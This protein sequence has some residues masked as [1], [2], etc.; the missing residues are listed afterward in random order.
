MKRIPMKT[1]TIILAAAAVLL[2]FE[3]ANAQVTYRV[4]ATR[5]GLVGHTTANGHVIQPNDRF[6]ALPSRTVLNSN[7]GTTYT[8]TISNPANGKT[9]TNVPVWDIGPWNCDDN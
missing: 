3:A 4:Y 9:A 2:S 6:V 8:V 5:V 7:G 1:K